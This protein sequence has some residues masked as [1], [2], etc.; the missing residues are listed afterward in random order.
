MYLLARLKK[1]H[2]VIFALELSSFLKHKILLKI[3]YTLQ[4]FPFASLEL[5]ICKY[6]VYYYITLYMDVFINILFLCLSLCPAM[7]WKLTLRCS[8]ASFLQSILLS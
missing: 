1:R 6:S 7:C 4:L 5:G 2:F 3:C 8:V